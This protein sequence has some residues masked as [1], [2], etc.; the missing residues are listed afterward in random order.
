MTSVLA[1]WRIHMLHRNYWRRLIET[2]AGK[3]WNSARAAGRIVSLR[4]R[5]QFRYVHRSTALSLSP[6]S[7][8]CVLASVVLRCRVYRAGSFSNAPV[9]SQQRPGPVLALLLAPSS[10]TCFPNYA[11]SVSPFP[12]FR[13]GSVFPTSLRSLRDRMQARPSP[14]GASPVPAGLPRSSS[15][16]LR[17]H[18]A[19]TTLSA[20]QMP[21]P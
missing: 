2:S 20:P 6:P 17:S 13:E 14:F 10:N 19:P 7:F 4:P 11:P 16:A 18:R 8:R 21:F 9:T 3:N 1:P 12:Q 15:H 5:R